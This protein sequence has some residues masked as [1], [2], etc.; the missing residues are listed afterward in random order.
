VKEEEG[1]LHK[2]WKEL[3]VIVVDGHEKSASFLSV[4]RP[5]PDRYTLCKI[6]RWNW[7]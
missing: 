6:S 4:E 5:P 7:L 3:D 1:L 2:E